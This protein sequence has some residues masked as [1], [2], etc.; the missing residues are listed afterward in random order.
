MEKFLYLLVIDY[1]DLWGTSMSGGSAI[2][3]TVVYSTDYS[4]GRLSLMYEYQ[5]GFGPLHSTG[6]SQTAQ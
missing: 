1:S 5:P 2:L 6:I 3:C 4:Y